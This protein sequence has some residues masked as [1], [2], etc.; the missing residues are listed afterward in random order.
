VKDWLTRLVRLLRRE[1]STDGQQ[2]GKL[3]F[4]QWVIILAGLGIALMILANYFNVQY[5]FQEG[6]SDDLAS[7]DDTPTEEEVDIEVEEM[8]VALGSGKG[9]SSDMQDYEEYLENQLK[10]ILSHIQGAG[11]VTVMVQVDSTEEIVYE[12]DRHT[13][14]SMTEENDREG[15]SRNAEEQSREE[16]LVKITQ[17][18][19]ESPLIVKTKKPQ[20]R[21]VLV[22][23]SGAEHMQV[24]AWLSEAVQR[25]LEVPAHRVSVMPGQE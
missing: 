19:D 5:S 4:I 17:G 14:S 16:Q 15:G 3:S 10:D 12:K 7:Y 8:D 9:H 2:E 13:Q 11:E 18:N 25:V 6:G 22:V 20:V 21:G 23:A 1:P 24:K